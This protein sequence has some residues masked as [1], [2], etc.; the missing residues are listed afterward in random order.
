M[1]RCRIVA[2]MLGAVGN[3]LRTHWDHTAVAVLAA[4]TLLG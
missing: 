4:I 3:T 1:V 2:L